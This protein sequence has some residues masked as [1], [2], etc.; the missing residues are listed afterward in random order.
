MSINDELDSLL[1][2]ARKAFWASDYYR[3]KDYL[4]RA[5]PISAPINPTVRYSIDF[6]L[7]ILY[8]LFKEEE[9]SNSQV[10]FLENL[11]DKVEESKRASKEKLKS[12]KKMSSEAR[13]S[14]FRTDRFWKNYSSALSL[15]IA[16]SIERRDLRTLLHQAKLMTLP[17]IR[18]AGKLRYSILPETF[19]ITARAYSE[20]ELQL[21]RLD[22]DEITHLDWSDISAIFSFSDGTANGI[23]RVE[24]LV[25][26]D[27]V[28]GVE[29]Q[30]VQSID[31]NMKRLSDVFFPN[32]QNGMDVH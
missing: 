11:Y 20:S 4:E 16:P 10:N 13:I 28:P 25:Y 14:I 24:G 26:L 29:S 32:T 2:L 19:S 8:S 7:A 17:D 12:L 1:S 27:Q 6:D 18:V 9:K 31:R 23:A 3:A 21:D 15:F 30:V 5:H 22:M